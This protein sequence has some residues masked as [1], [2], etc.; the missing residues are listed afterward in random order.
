MVSRL[1]KQATKLANTE[2]AVM[3]NLWPAIA[4]VLTIVSCASALF[5]R[6]G[7]ASQ[8]VR[9]TSHQARA[10]GKKLDAISQDLTDHAKHCDQ[11]RILMFER[12][13]QHEN[14]LAKLEE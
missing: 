10:N 13:G 2:A 7:A 9:A 4:V 5:W 11:E 8:E 3:E 14:R 12:M 6:L 1:D